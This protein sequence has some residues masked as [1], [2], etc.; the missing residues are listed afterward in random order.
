VA[1]QPAVAATDRI[2]R[3]PWGDA[4]AAA[5]GLA[6]EPATRRT[7]AP[8]A[9]WPGMGARRSGPAAAWLAKTANEPSRPA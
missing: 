9:G 5:V 2:T 3:T 4:T 1:V 6:A 8:A 7:D